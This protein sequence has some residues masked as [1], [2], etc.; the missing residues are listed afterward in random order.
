MPRRERHPT[1]LRWC[2]AALLAAALALAGACRQSAPLPNAPDPL[3]LLARP[4]L[5]GQTFDPGMLKGKL[6]LIN[7]WSPT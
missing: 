7:F 4:T 1:L 2:D 6:V 3:A 5:T